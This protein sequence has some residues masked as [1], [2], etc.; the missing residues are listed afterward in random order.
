MRTSARNLARARCTAGSTPTAYDQ[1]ASACRVNKP[2]PRSLAM[3]QR[4][5]G[6]NPSRL[7][8][9]KRVPREDRCMA[10]LLERSSPGLMR[11][12][13]S[14]P[15]LVDR[16]AGVPASA[17][18][19][20]SVHMQAC[21]W[22]APAVYCAHGR[23]DCPRCGSQR[24]TRQPRGRRGCSGCPQTRT[25]V[26]SGSSWP[27]AMIRT[28]PAARRSSRSNVPALPSKPATHGAIARRQG[29]NK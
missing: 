12:F 8:R 28:S 5:P 3:L 16:L 6:W 21:T 20:P 22:A 9:T 29:V 10:A 18:P 7:P 11:T 4:C 26:A 24:A 25:L 2:V 14:S 1:R 19:S 27:H 15:S 23:Y 13:I 17:Q